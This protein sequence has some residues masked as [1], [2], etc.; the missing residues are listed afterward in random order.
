MK[1]W[2]AAV[3][4]LISALA[5][6]PFL[7]PAKDE[8]PSVPTDAA[9]VREAPA[10]ILLNVFDTYTGETV[11]IPIEEYVAGVVAAEMPADYA[12]EALKAQAVAARTYAVQKSRFFSGEGCAR[13]PEADVCASSACCQ[14]Y[15]SAQRARETLGESA[16]RALAAASL[17]A[18]STQGEVLVFR[19][20]PIRALYHACA[21]GHTEDAENVY[22]SALAYL[23]GVES[24]GEEQ[25][26]QFSADTT[27]TLSQLRDAFAGDENVFISPSVPL[28]EQFEILSR[29]AA[30]RVTGIRVGLTAMTGTD[31]RKALSLKSANFTM[32]FGADSI[33]FSTIGSGHGVGMSQT[34]ADAMAGIGNDYEQILNWYYTDVEIADLSD[35]LPSEAGS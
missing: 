33:R 28:E 32:T 1:N 19:G 7:F 24:P 21:G 34:G 25:Y 29:S 18:A 6:I 11:S 20:H 14:G 2:L 3:S 8:I 17:A 31:F 30:G 26:A 5:L 35:L 10:E 12:P 27:R 22:A 15:L 23:R 9:A 13:H 4:T 16:D